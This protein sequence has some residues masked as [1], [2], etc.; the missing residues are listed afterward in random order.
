MKRSV[1]QFVLGFLTVGLILGGAVGFA[2]ILRGVPLVG[3]VASLLFLLFLLDRVQQSRRSAEWYCGA[4]ALCASGM[5]YIG[6]F[7]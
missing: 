6:F 4:L 3:I 5:I 1:L 7:V 2:W